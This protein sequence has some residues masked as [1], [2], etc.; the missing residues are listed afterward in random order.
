MHTEDSGFVIFE[1]W[2]LLTIPLPR[3]NKSWYLI[4]FPSL[5]IF[6]KGN[7]AGGRGGV[8]SPIGLFP[9]SPS[10][11]PFSPTITIQPT[12]RLH[13]I[14]HENRRLVL[15]KARPEITITI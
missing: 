6:G 7:K 12:V 5:P 15:G 8:R 2:R 1:R 13:H 11:E 14:S 10:R 4:P 3:S 9:L